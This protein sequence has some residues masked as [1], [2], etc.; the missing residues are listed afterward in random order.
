[1]SKN[2]NNAVMFEAL[3]GRT[4]M[5]AAPVYHVEAAAVK[6]AS[7]VVKAPLRT[8]SKLVE[9]AVTDKSISY[10]NFSSEPL[11]S[12]KGP[13]INDINQGYLGDCYLLSTLS[14]VAKTDPALIKKEI[15]ANADGTYTVSFGAKLGTHIKVDAELPV[16]PDGQ[17]AYAGLGQQGSLW[18]SLVEKAYVSYKNL[19][20]NS[21]ASINGGWMS[22][23]FA[24][25]GLKSQTVTNEGSSAA[26]VATLAAD[27][28]AG[29]FTT[30][31]TASS[32]PGNSPMIADHAY[33]VDSVNVANNTVTFR[34]PWGNGSANDGYV[35]VSA[36]QAYAAFTGIVV[37]HA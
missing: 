15:V 33:E 12:S 31:G 26:L 21:Y 35:T 2:Q 29:D 8:T 16:W 22:D 1:M 27:L 36:E 30:F 5:S 34:N 3:E 17:V 18:V 28:K 10:K 19:K 32:L 14:S 37:S 7:P 4:M 6:K 23:A 24:A 11:F 9:P 20:A 25:L 13:S